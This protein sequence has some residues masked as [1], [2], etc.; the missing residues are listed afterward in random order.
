M[1]VVCSVGPNPY[2][3]RRRTVEA[4]TPNRFAACLTPDYQSD[5]G[6]GSAD[7][8]MRERRAAVLQRVERA[9]AVSHLVKDDQIA[10]VN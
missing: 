2:R 9:L 5:V 1:G 3:I 6:S 8:R 4:T 10:V 7:K